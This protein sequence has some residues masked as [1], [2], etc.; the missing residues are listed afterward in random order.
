MY[1]NPSL[2]RYSCLPLSYNHLLQA[3]EAPQITAA[4]SGLRAH[5]AREDAEKMDP[6]NNQGLPKE[7]QGMEAV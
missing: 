5:A 4:F 1:S 3:S 2:H 7:T 6:K